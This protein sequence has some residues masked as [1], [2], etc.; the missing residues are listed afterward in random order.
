[1]LET[2]MNI[3]FVRKIMIL[4]GQP[5]KIARKGTRELMTYPLTILLPELHSSNLQTF[6][7]RLHIPHLSTPRAETEKETH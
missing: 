3:L 7:R 5:I 4:Q 6:R 1:M 2:Y